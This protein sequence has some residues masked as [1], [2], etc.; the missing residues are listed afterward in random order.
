MRGDTNIQDRRRP[1]FGDQDEVDLVAG[2]TVIGPL[3]VKEMA[4]LTE[5]RISEDEIIYGSE[6]D[7]EICWC[8]AL[9]QYRCRNFVFERIVEGPPLHESRRRSEG[10]PF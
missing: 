9:L 5:G 8:S 6:A 10:G 4:L 2:S 1:T 3:S 7:K